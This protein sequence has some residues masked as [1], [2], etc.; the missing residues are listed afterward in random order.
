MIQLGMDN[1]TKEFV[2]SSMIDEK[3]EKR[4]PFTK[5]GALALQKY[6]DDR[7]EGCVCSSSYDFPEDEGCPQEL[8][9]IIFRE[10]D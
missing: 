7:G 3:N 9:D 1:K 4:F 6:L 5:E 10:G 8:V 2:S